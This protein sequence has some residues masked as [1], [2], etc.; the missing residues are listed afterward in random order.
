MWPTDSIGWVYVNV[1]CTPV[2][3]VTDVIS[4]SG[5]WEVSVIIGSLPGRRVEERGSKIL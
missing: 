5:W 4:F 1:G 3:I 2:G